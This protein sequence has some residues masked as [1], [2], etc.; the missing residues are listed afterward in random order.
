[1]TCLSIGLGSS[2]G[3]VFRALFA[4]FLT[5]PLI[6]SFFRGV[7]DAD[8]RCGGMDDDLDDFAVG[9]NIRRMC[10]FERRVRFKRVVSRPPS[11]PAH[12]TNSKFPDTI[13]SSRI[14]DILD[15]IASSLDT[16]PLDC[17]LTPKSS[18]SNPQETIQESLRVVVFYQTLKTGC[19][20]PWMSMII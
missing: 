5:T 8:L 20:H 13:Q 6:A 7:L 15:S 19:H 12:Q 11:K 3:T 2:S 10:Y 4:P 17:V 14:H 1:V 18:P 9:R 16:D